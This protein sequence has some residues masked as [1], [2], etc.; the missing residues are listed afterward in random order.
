MTTSPNYHLLVS[1][2]MGDELELA[3][4]STSDIRVL[5]AALSLLGEY[6][7]RRL[8]IDDVAA[9]AKVGRRTIFRRF[10]S[11]D[12]LVAAT[13]QREVS[14]AVARITVAADAAS[15]P[16]EALTAAYCQLAEIAVDHPVIRRLARVEPEVLVELWRSGS[17]S[18]HEMIRTV[19]HSLVERVAES[20]AQSSA[21][22]DGCDI[23]CRLLFADELLARAPENGESRRETVRRLLNATVALD[24]SP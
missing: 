10:G 18:G 22:K 11:K 16:L 3:E 8:T 20:A 12:A 13:Y 2:V 21:L 7:E 17:P 1:Q 6:G 23:L 4:R 24:T 19:L 9:K 14:R 15:S 5:D